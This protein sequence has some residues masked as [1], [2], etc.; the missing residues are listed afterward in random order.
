MTRVLVLGG[1][2]FLGAAIVETALAGG[3]DVTT[4]HRGR[5]GVDIAGVPIIR[6]DRANLDDLRSLGK[7]GPWDIVV[8]TSSYVPRETLV[9][10]HALEPV[11]D[12]Y[13]I[14]SSVSVYRR[15]PVEPLSDDAPILDCPPDAGPG[16]G[17]DADPGPRRYGFG[18]AGCERAVLKVFGEDRSILLRPGVILGPR[19][20]IGRLTWWL[21]RMRRG[22]RVLAPG[23]PDRAIQPVDVP[24][25]DRCRHLGVDVRRRSSSRAQTGRIVG[26]RAGAGTSDPRTVGLPPNEPG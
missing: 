26:Y 17:Y 6:G 23:R 4:F 7:A 16:F 14:V 3:L 18:K 11:V 20:Y 2:W 13:V 24:K 22:G 8:D 19:E 21:Q 1:S 25:R 15:W 10:A 9:L 5:T 12:R